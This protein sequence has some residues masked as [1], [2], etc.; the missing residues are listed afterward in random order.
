MILLTSVEWDHQDFYTDV[1]M[2]ETAFV[3]FIEK[4]PIGGVLLLMGTALAF[5]E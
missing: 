1:S 4:L 2:I 3:K 5:G